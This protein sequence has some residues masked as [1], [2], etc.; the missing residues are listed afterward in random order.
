MHSDA[1]VH[2]SKKYICILKSEILLGVFFP[3]I[4]SPRTDALG[5]ATLCALMASNGMQ[6]DQMF[7]LSMRGDGPLRGLLA[8][9]TGKG[10]ARGYVGN[11]SLSDDFSLREAVGVGTVQVVKNHPDW[12]RPY[13]GITSIRHGDI[14]RDVGEFHHS[15]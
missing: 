5:R 4:P 6:E 10:E 1:I 12:P 14:D 8:I 15:S 3:P 2:S 9:V 7:Q 13:N 11:P